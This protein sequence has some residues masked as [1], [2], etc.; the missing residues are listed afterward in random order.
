MVDTGIHEAFTQPPF[1][2]TMTD[3]MLGAMDCIPPGIIKN[4]WL[5]GEYS[6]FPDEAKATYNSDDDS[7]YDE[8]EL[9]EI[10]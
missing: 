9:K 2:A 3:W 7:D 8:I 6:Y 4:A 5:H 10:V 1:R